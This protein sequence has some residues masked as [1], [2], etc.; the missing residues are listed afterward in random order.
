MRLGIRIGGPLLLLA[1]VVALVGCSQGPAPKASRVRGQ[2]V[3]KGKPLP[4][5]DLWIRSQQHEFRIPIDGNGYFA[6]GNVPVGKY[7]VRVYTDPK[8]I[9]ARNDAMK[10]DIYGGPLDP[11]GRKHVPKLKPP[12]GIKPPDVPYKA[13][14][15]KPLKYVPIP[16]KYTKYETSG[17][18]LEVVPG[19]K[20]DYR[21]ELQ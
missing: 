8:I 17:L 9:K 2:V 16:K 3:Y 20:D 21:I 14:D 18:T 13:S 12:P 5:G 15:A 19:A 11:E 10:E 7:D 6:H 4:G 1:A